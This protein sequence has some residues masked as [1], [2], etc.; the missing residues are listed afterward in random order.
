MVKIVILKQGEK[1]KYYTSNSALWK[2]N[3]L[4][5]KKWEIDRHDFNKPLVKN[6]ITIRVDYALRSSEV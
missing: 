2:D 6:D 1:E 3:K 5:F 4:P